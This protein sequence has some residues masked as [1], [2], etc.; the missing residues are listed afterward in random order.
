MDLETPYR[1]FIAKTTTYSIESDDDLLRVTNTGAANATLPKAALCTGNKATKFIINDTTSTNNVTILAT[2][3]DTLVGNVSLL[4]GRGA[5]AVSDGASKWFLVGPSGAGAGTISESDLSFSDITTAD[6]TSSQHGLMPKLTPGTATA[7][8]PVTLG[9][10]KDLDTLALDAL[11]GHDSSFGVTGLASTQGGAIVVTGGTS[12]TAGNAGGAVTNVGGTPGTTGVGGAVGLTGGVGGATSGT[13]G[14]AAVAGGAGT[15]GNAAGG[16]GSLTGGAG[17]G[18]AAGG[19]GKA[20]GGAGGATGAGGA[21]QVTG[22]AGGATSGTGGAATITGGAGTN[23]NATGG[24]ASLVGGAGQGTGAGAASQV[25][26][27]A[28]GAGATGNGG[29]AVVSGGAA[30]STNG[31]GGDVT[32]TPGVG[33]GTGFGGN[34]VETSVRKLVKQATPTALTTS[35]TLT[36]AHILV[37]ILTANQGA[38]A[39]ASYTLP[40]GTDFEAGFSSFATDQ[41][42]D[43]SLINI[44]TNAAEDVDILT[45]VGWTLVGSMAVQSN[46]AITSKSVGRFRARRTAAN[47]FTLYRLS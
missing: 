4:P 26:G 41:A 11:T 25:T 42:F 38:G 45:A 23:G 32:L 24:I 3:G 8:A 34:I 7:S 40:T 16:V 21:A 36:A 19:V 47:T 10:D 43:F 17:Q 18:S 39:T 37:G 30:L 22:G 29:A 28:S 31:Q 1:Q 5:Y 2:S 12:S 27:G 14:A 20:V 9:A 46:D 44:S 15:N 13:G 6:A 33:T 35:T